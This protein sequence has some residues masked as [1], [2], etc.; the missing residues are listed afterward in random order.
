MDLN[1]YRQTKSLSFSQLGDLLGWSKAKAYQHCGDDRPCIKLVDAH[2]VVS[3]TD[4]EVGL[5][6]L[7]PEDC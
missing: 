5:E 6:D 3:K 1:T 4:G 2:T 7:L